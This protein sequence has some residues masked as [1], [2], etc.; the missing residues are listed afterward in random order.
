[1]SNSSLY[2]LEKHIY[3]KNYEGYNT[4]IQNTMSIENI[5]KVWYT[6]VCAYI[7]VFQHI[8]LVKLKRVNEFQTL[9]II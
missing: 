4:Q 8:I 5:F 2:I 9:K 3:F 7:Y 6:N 1:M